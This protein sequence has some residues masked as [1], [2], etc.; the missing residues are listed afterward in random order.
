[1]NLAHHKAAPDYFFSGLEATNHSSNILNRTSMVKASKRETHAKSDIK[2]KQRYGERAECFMTFKIS[3]Q[4]PP[5]TVKNY[6][7][8]LYQFKGMRRRGRGEEG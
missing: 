7:G 8:K 5:M 3:E 6:S 4:N 2:R 1:M